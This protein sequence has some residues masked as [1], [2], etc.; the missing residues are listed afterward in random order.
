MANQLLQFRCIPR[1]STTTLP[2]IISTKETTKQTISTEE[3]TTQE[4]TASEEKT[5]TEE[6]I[7]ADSQSTQK[8]T[9]TTR[10][11]P[12]QENQCSGANHLHRIDD[13]TKFLWK[14][15]NKNH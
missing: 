11:T 14:Y 12:Q 6:S 1:Y 15:E 8:N 2:P 13:C 7:T 5:T 9:T 10:T 4:I 3:L